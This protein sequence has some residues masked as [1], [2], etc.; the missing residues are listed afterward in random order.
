MKRPKS[1]RRSRRQPRKAEGEIS[2]QK[3][4]QKM[5]KIN[6][7]PNE[8]WEEKLSKSHEMADFG[9]GGAAPAA[10]VCVCVGVWGV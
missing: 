3:L 2:D 7:V 9:Q 1:G 6:I 8:I 5:E 10:R 4:D